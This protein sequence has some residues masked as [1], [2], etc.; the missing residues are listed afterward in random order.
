MSR[1][2]F[3][4]NNKKEE[5]VDDG[6]T[7]EFSF[8]PAK[9]QELTN[10][11]SADAN[12]GLPTVGGGNYTSYSGYDRA[13]SGQIAGVEPTYLNDTEIKKALNISNAAIKGATGSGMLK[14]SN[15]N[16]ISGLNVPNA[17][18]F[19]STYKEPEPFAPLEIPTTPLST[20]SK[21]D[22][23]IERGLDYE[24]LKNVPLTKK[25]KTSEGIQEMQYGTVGQ[26]LET[27]DIMKQMGTLNKKGERVPVVDM[28]T[29]STEKIKKQTA[30]D[31]TEIKM[32][33]VLPVQQFTGKGLETET[34]YKAYIPKS[35]LEMYK[36]A[37]EAKRL[38]Q[39]AAEQTDAGMTSRVIFD[40]DEDGNK[41]LGTDRIV[42]APTL[43]GLQ[44]R[45]GIRR[46][47]PLAPGSGGLP[48]S[49]GGSLS[50]IINSRAADT[51]MT[52]NRQRTNVIAQEALDLAN[53]YGINLDVDITPSQRVAVLNSLND[54]RSINE[55]TSRQGRSN[56]NRIF[57]NAVAE[58]TRIEDQTEQF[59]AQTGLTS[60]RVEAT[61]ASF[62]E[63]ILDDNFDAANNPEFESFIK[64]QQFAATLQRALDTSKDV[65]EAVK[66]GNAYITGALKVIKQN[67]ERLDQLSIEK[68][69][70]LVQQLQQQ[71]I[72]LYRII[73]EQLG[74]FAGRNKDAGSKQAI[75]DLFNK[76]NIQVKNINKEITFVSEDDDNDDEKVSINDI[77]KVYLDINKLTDTTNMSTKKARGID[78]T[79]AKKQKILNLIKNVDW[80]KTL[81][82]INGISNR[83]TRNTLLDTISAGGMSDALEGY[84][85]K[86]K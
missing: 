8:G 65:D 70:E 75:E 50:Q 71:N 46:R 26:E 54:M 6:L 44:S 78:K 72:D 1:D 43:K 86:K 3:F 55:S 32:T 35:Q 45:E 79:N 25:F 58:K 22:A 80:D 48:D 7:R 30:D 56:L 29:Y 49:E 24:S 34:A 73:N 39:L 81:E 62:T 33:G 18:K 68:N 17:P 40:T 2:R 13:V 57:S 52:A 16:F 5:K 82:K 27:R 12:F 66:I 61:G 31:G 15:E 36:D 37:Q 19:T 41:I 4:K 20:R 42:M 28:G 76:F 60:A 67:D 59:T 11:V 77:E 85:V 83:R 74:N 9:N 63:Q 84:L 38:R 21:T 53:T 64:S 69:P 47:G 23:E 51:S 10:S 14:A